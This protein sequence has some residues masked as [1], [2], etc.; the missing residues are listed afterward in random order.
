MFEYASKDEHCKEGGNTHPTHMFHVI[1]CNTK[2]G[3]T[4][5][6]IPFFARIFFGGTCTRW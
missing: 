1:L 4:K 5:F 3:F 2:V 6:G